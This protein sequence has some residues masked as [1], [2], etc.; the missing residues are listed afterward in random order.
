MTVYGPYLPKDWDDLCVDAKCKWI[1]TY[2]NLKIPSPYADRIMEV[3]E[4]M[5]H[6]LET[7][8]GLWCVDHQPENEPDAF[9]LSHQSIHGK[10]VQDV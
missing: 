1:K 10:E 4:A 2:L 3:F 6:D 8:E 5:R 9:Q 7:S